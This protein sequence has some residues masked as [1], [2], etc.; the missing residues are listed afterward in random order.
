MFKEIVEFIDIFNFAFKIVRSFSVVG[1]MTI[2]CYFYILMSYN[3]FKGDTTKLSNDLCAV[4]F[5]IV[6]FVYSVNEFC[7]KGM[8]IKN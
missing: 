5:F 6:N 3:Y 1:G 4:L 8:K 2:I 7:F